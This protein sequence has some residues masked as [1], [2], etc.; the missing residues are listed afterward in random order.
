[1]T[2]GRRFIPIYFSPKSLLVA[3]LAVSFSLIFLHVSLQYLVYVIGITKLHLL[4]DVFDVDRE[5]SIPT[6]FSQLILL[7]SAVAAGIVG[8]YKR[9]TRLAYGRHWL[10][11]ASVFLFLSVDEIAGIHERLIDVLA[12]NQASLSIGLNSWYLFAI[13]MV[14]GV[15]LPLLR[16]WWQLPAKT[17]YMLVVSAAVYLFGAVFFDVFDGR[18]DGTGFLHD[19]LLVGIEEAFEMFGASLFLYTLYDY[20]CQEKIMPVIGAQ[21]ITAANPGELRS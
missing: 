21:K 5:D 6:W 19:G 7:G 9:R 2:R 10:A 12:R 14:G 18:Y 4:S 15:A 17:R 1:M 3:A 8:I 16:F 13:I 11:V 20:V